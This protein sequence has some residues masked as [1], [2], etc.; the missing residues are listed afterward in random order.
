METNYGS[1]GQKYL[2]AVLSGKKTVNIDN[3][4]SVYFAD[5][6]TMLGDKRIDFD[7]NDDIVIDGKRYA[8]T[9]GLYK[10][11]FKKFPDEKINTNADKESYLKILLATNAHRRGHNVHE[12]VKSNKGHKYMNIIGPLV[13]GNKVGKGMPR[14]VM[15]NDNK[16]DYVHWDDPNELV[17]RLRLLEALRQAGHNAHD[18]EILSIIDELRKAGLIIN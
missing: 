5:D 15:L 6:G 3:V 8:G 16:V 13:L 10:L 9:Q 2:G 11:I 14:A 7:K 4:Y 1:L 18:N 17:D 12:R